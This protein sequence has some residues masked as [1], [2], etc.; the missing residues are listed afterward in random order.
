M[1]P[2][3]DVVFG[4]FLAAMAGLAVIAVRWAVRRDRA[5]RANPVTGDAPAD[6]AHDH[7]R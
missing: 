4:I 5:A 2:T 3:F 1:T 6:G 7:D